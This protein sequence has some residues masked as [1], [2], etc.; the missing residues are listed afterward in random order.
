MP[1]MKTLS[2]RRV[3]STICWAWASV[4]AIGFSQRTC[5]PA[6]MAASATSAWSAL[7]VQTLTASSSS[8][9]NIFV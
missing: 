2:T 1:I 7:G 6:P 3:A 4:S 8:S 5:L 9:A